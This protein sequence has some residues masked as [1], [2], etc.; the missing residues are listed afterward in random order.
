MF[1]FQRI[2]GTT[3]NTFLYSFQFINQFPIENEIIF[4]NNS[5]LIEFVWQQQQVSRLH[6][7]YVVLLSIPLKSKDVQYDSQKGLLLKPPL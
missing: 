2:I 4:K 1:V 6:N 5:T 3:F 7:W